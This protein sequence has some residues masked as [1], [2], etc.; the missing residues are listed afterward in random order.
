MAYQAIPDIVTVVGDSYCQPIAD[1]L[2]R[3]LARPRAKTDEASTGYFENGYSVSIIILL[4]ALLESY[5]VRLRYLRAAS[6]AAGGRSVPDLLLMLF[7]HLP[8]H[9]ALIEVFLLRNIILHNHMW[10]LDVRL[11]D[12][13][14]VSMMRS[15]EDFD[16]QFNQHYH[17]VVDKTTRR[18]KLL[19]LNVNPVGVDRSEVRKVFDVALTTLSFLQQQEPNLGW[20]ADTSVAYERKRTK[21]CDLLTKLDNAL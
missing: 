18:T 16:F 21:F 15:P 10:E 1:L 8:N 14:Q 3:F 13:G 19:A 5:A 9:A 7:P 6:V 17:K 4:V 2:A 20:R 11:R 12:E